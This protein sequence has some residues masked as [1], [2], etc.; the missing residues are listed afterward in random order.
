M[1]I[2]GCPSHP[3]LSTSTSHCHDGAAQ[4]VASVALVCTFYTAPFHS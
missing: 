4:I 3:S 1:T 2:L